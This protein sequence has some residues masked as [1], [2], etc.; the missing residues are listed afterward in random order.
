MERKKLVID[1]FPKEK[2]LFSVGRLDRDTTGLLIITNDGHFAQKVIHPS[3][4]IEK[5][6]LVKTFQEV[7]HEHLVKISKGAFVDGVYVRPLSVKKVR[8]GT[9]KVVVKEGRKREV[10]VLVQKAELKI[11][12]L[13]RI[14]IGGLHLGPLPEGS[15]RELTENEKEDIFKK[16]SS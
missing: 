1:L 3:S 4:N 11:L 7:T 14:R 9:L 15:Y 8:R 10:R 2:R 6:Y 5:E 12:S 16:S 13:T